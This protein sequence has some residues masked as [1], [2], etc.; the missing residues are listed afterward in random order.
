M[1]LKWGDLG[2]GFFK[3]FTI[4]TTGYL[5][6]K[7]PSSFMTKSPRSRS[8]C[9]DDKP[10][11]YVKDDSQSQFSVIEAN[12]LML[13]L[14]EA[15]EKTSEPDEQNIA[16]E[17][18][19]EIKNCAEEVQENIENIILVDEEQGKGSSLVLKEEV[20]ELDEET[21]L[22]DVGDEEED[23][24]SEIDYFLIEENTEEEEENVEEESYMLSTEELNKKFEDFIRKM[25]EGLRIEAQRQLV[26]SLMTQ[27]KVSPSNIIYAMHR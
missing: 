27:S 25:K 23:K 24:G 19:I 8:S 4:L 26:M 11:K 13:E 12:E 22:F 16:V 6:F 7:Y 21:E 3:L 9:D 17:Q 20:K 15:D 5:P 2:G 10:S 14:V 18:V 1:G